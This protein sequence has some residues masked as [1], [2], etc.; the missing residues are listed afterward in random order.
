MVQDNS[1]ELQ[2]SFLFTLLSNAEIVGGKQRAAK[3]KAIQQA[4]YIKKIMAQAS[5]IC[6]GGGQDWP[7]LCGGAHTGLQW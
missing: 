6:K 1:Q 7:R 2:K 5:K 4:E 3:L